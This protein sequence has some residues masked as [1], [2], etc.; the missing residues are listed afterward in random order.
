MKRFL[1]ILGIILGVILILIIAFVAFLKFKPLPNYNETVAVQDIEVSV[2]SLTLAQGK[3]LVDH[4]CAGCHRPEGRQY[5][6]GYFED[7]AANKAFGD[8]YVP[9]IT[10]SV[11]DGIGDYTEGE[12]YRLLRTGVSKEGLA[13]LPVMPRFV[14]MSDEDVEAIIAFLKSDDPAVQASGPKQPTHKPSL[15]AKALL[16][17]AIKPTPYKDSYPTKPSLDEQVAYGKYLVTS[18]MGCYFCHS[19]SLQEWNLDNPELTP[20]YLGG[21]TEFITPE[22]TIVSP[23]LLMDSTSNVGKWNENQF[24]GAVMYGQRE[25]KPSFQKPMHPYPML[26]SLEI[27]AIYAYLKDYS[28]K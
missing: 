10:Q 2:D 1:K 4:V 21:G 22:Y 7:M 14:L 26:D 24:I 16:S 17:F 23:S 27:G 5:V 25:G 12:I 13:L 9:N 19:A 11:E 18:Q 8:I 6:G 28:S 20:G 15:L 3:K